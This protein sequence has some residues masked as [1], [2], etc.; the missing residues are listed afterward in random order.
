MGIGL[1]G[2]IQARQA[3]NIAIRASLKTTC[4]V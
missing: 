4:M 2:E 1:F 3:E